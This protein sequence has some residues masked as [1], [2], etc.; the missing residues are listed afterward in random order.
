MSKEILIKAVKEFFRVVLISIIPILI[1]SL[2]NNSIEIK[3]VLVV[4]GVAG[5]RFID[6]L[7]H[8][9]GLELEEDTDKES[10]F[11]TGLTRF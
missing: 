9:F 7:L 6:K 1:S 2:E 4:A 8:E 5:L 3:V 10:L 11:T